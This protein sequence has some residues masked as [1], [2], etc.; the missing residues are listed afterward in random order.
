MRVRV[1]ICVCACTHMYIWIVWWY[2]YLPEYI[3]L[4]QLIGF[5]KFPFKTVGRI[6]QKIGRYPRVLLC[7]FC[8]KW[9]VGTIHIYLNNISEIF[10]TNRDECIYFTCIYTLTY[11][12]WYKCLEHLTLSNKHIFRSIFT[13]FLI[14]PMLFVMRMYKCIRFL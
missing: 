7:E 8:T 2:M 1:Y 3:K 13:L 9:D 4:L 6:F 5:H 11:S 14:Y 12:S 10:F